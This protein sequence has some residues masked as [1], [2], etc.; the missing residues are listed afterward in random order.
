MPPIVMHGTSV[1]AIGLK[2]EDAEATVARAKALGAEP[3][4]QPVGPGRAA[5][6]QPSAA[7]AAA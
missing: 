6:S 1:Y 5:P 3:F 7:S 2:V 4:E